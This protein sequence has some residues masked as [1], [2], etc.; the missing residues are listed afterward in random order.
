MNYPKMYILTNLLLMRFQNVVSK[1][2]K[3]QSGCL[4]N[5]AQI[6]NCRAICNLKYLSMGIFLF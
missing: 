1:K 5:S 3:L 4:N 2:L 6:K